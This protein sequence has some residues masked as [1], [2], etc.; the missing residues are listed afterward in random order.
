[1]KKRFIIFLNTKYPTK[2]KEFYQKLLTGKTIIAADGGIRF[3]SRN[4]IKPDYLIGDFDSLPRLSKAYLSQIK[5]IAHPTRKN[6]TDGHLALDLALEM[7]ADEITLC[8]A[9]SEKEIDHTLGNIFLLQIVADFN[10]TS[11]KN[12]TAKI[13]TPFGEIFLIDNSIL[14][15]SGTA[16][17]NIS[18]LP[19]NSKC[20]LDYSGLEF[21]APGTG[22]KLGDSLTLRNRMT[23]PICRIKVRGKALIFHS[24]GMA[25][26]KRP[27]ERGKKVR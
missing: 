14:K 18:V 24:I 6:K 26:P 25:M 15:I 10:Q 19:L 3:L 1:M 7:G 16:G 23:G 27:K 13:V 21:T 8:G 5:V 11:G 4:R 9:I 22:L 17:D 12:I 20:R 2:Y